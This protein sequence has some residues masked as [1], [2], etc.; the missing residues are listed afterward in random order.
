MEA[1]TTVFEKFAL[2]VAVIIVMIVAIIVLFKYITEQNEKH[3][4]LVKDQS[5]KYDREMREQND[6]YFEAYK[7]IT[8]SNNNVTNALNN[9]T[10]TIESNTRLIEKLVDKLDVHCS[11]GNNQ[12]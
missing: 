4:A 12:S 8:E 5:D 10:K 2:P 3:D 9:N 1:A 7:M 6:K 11:S